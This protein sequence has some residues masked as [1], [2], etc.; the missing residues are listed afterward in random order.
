[1]V[2]SDGKTAQGWLV[3]NNR[4][5]YDIDTIRLWTDGKIDNPLCIPKILVS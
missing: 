3:H 1:M 4:D 5:D 2:I